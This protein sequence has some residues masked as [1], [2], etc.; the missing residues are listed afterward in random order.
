MSILFSITRKPVGTSLKRNVLIF[1][2]WVASN[3]VWFCSAEVTYHVKQSKVVWSSSARCDRPK[4]LNQ[5]VS[6]KGHSNFTI[7]QKRG[8]SD[9]T[10][11]TEI[12]LESHIK[13]HESRAFAFFANIW[14][15][16]SNL[17][18]KNYLGCFLPEMILIHLQPEQSPYNQSNI[19]FFGVAFPPFYLEF[20]ADWSF[21]SFGGVGW[22]GR[23]LD[24]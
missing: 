20:H 16:F 10:L 19:A 15:L 14:S 21:L 4:Y 3:Q 11:K 9:A 8:L 17:S 6:V 7:V 13:R 18:G 2:K 22:E 12:L 23:V 1:V 24:E 5:V